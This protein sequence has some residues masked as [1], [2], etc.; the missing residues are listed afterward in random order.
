MPTLTPSVGSLTSASSSG[1]SGAS[2]PERKP[3]LSQRIRPGRWSLAQ[4]FTHLLRSSSSVSTSTSISRPT[5]ESLVPDESS[6]VVA[7]DEKDGDRTVTE[8][9]LELSMSATST[10]KAKIY[11][12]LARSTSRS[13]SKSTRR[14]SDSATPDD[15]DTTLTTM[16]SMRSKPSTRSPSRP[17]SNNRPLSDQTART[18]STITPL[19][20]AQSRA[21]TPRTTTDG[22]DMSMPPP[23]V[24]TPASAKRKS[25]P[26]TLFG[27]SLPGRSR[28][29]TPKDER[30]DPIFS[31]PPTPAR[32]RPGFSS[33]NR[34]DKASVMPGP[35]SIPLHAPQP[36]P[37]AIKRASI[38]VHPRSRSSP[39]PHDERPPSSIESARG[40]CSPFFS[41]RIFNRSSSRGGSHSRSTSVSRTNSSSNIKGKA[42]A[43]PKVSV[44]KLN[45]RQTS[46]DNGPPSAGLVQNGPMSA[47]IGSFDFEPR[48]AGF[49]MKRSVSQGGTERGDHRRA[50]VRASHDGHPAAYSQ[51]TS[52]R[53]HMRAS[54]THTPRPEPFDPARSA[55]SQQ[56]TATSGT[57]AARAN[58]NAA[59]IAAGENG[60]SW[61]RRHGR[62]GW[63]GA[64]VHP[65]FAFESAASGSGASNGR[66][67]PIP[68]SEGRTRS[69]IPGSEARTRLDLSPR[70]RVH[71]L[72]PWPEREK[73]KEVELG[74]GLTWAP[75]KIRVREFTGRRDTPDHGE[76][77]RVKERERTQHAAKR[78]QRELGYR[79]A[80]L[81]VR[82]KADKEVTG[83]FRTVLGEQGFEKFKKYVRRFD[84]E[85]IPLDGAS[86]LL[87]RVRQLL[88]AAPPPG[89]SPREKRE[90]LDDLVRIVKEDVL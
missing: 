32:G 52:A 27:I 12:F 41:M 45:M 31:P 56:S 53:A 6:A 49:E 43:P 66:A 78:E 9:I 19:P 84:Q 73:E 63:V 7:E 77:E 24:P 62:Q 15:P 90:M 4:D 10:R 42:P 2:G 80:D 40:R 3:S 86:G 85:L 72:G 48:H 83:R 60:G 55:H 81:K 75:T 79:E 82:R 28:P 89:V 67:S 65:P 25:K 35:S 39:P 29:T 20:N 57:G 1:M 46:R 68:I 54:H 33:S 13:R 18:H 34:K 23:P 64:G 44:P 50:R 74:I 11:D 51:S 70:F 37:A 5:A 87:D 38:D 16:D 59:A 36:R 58:A 30:A 61:G 47:R 76:R 17:L 88:D 69:P 21:H 71:E 8:N 26:P 14:S 22:Y